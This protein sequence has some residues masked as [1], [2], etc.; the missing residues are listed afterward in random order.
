M[1]K[2]KHPRN[3]QEQNPQEKRRQFPPLRNCLNYTYVTR[4]LLELL[5]APFH[6][7]INLLNAVL[8]CSCYDSDSGRIIPET[9]TPYSTY[10]SN[11]LRDQRN[12]TSLL[13]SYMNDGVPR[14]EGTVLPN[15]VTFENIVKPQWSIK[16]GGE[17][18]FRRKV[19]FCIDNGDV[20]HLTED[21]LADLS[22]LCKDN[23]SNF[24][25]LVFLS[26]KYTIICKNNDAFRDIPSSVLYTTINDAEHQIVLM[27]TGLITLCEYDRDD[28]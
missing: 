22:A 1:E 18:L 19:L 8:N 25:E 4:L 14:G 11:M 15:A 24:F 17:E 5:N 6:Y 12:A 2:E 16:D 23:E 28:V 3:G 26:L 10:L 21:M 20:S 27:P 13:I 9:G 7:H